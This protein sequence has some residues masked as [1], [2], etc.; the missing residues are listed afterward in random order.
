MGVREGEGGG[1][2]VIVKEDRLCTWG[3]YKCMCEKEK[4]MFAVRKQKTLKSA[5]I[6]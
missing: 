1:G 6:L 4:L 2:G 3:I 5:I